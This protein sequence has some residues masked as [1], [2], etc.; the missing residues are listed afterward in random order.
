MNE[1][2]DFI[3]AI[4]KTK[5]STVTGETK[6]CPFC[7]R[8]ELHRSNVILKS[9]DHFLWMENKY[10][11]FENGYQTVLVEHKGC[12]LH[13][14]SYDMSHRRALLSFAYR[15]LQELKA[16]NRFKSVCM[17]KNH[18]LLSGS[19]IAHAHMQIVGWEDIDC[20]HDIKDRDFEGELAFESENVRVNISR[21]P[22]GESFEINIIA[23]NN[24]NGRDEMADA[25]ATSVDYLLTVLNPIHKSYNIAFYEHGDH[26]IA[27]VIPR[28]FS[29]LYV[30]AYAMS[31]RPITLHQV[32]QGLKEHNEKRK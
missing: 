4:A 29:S 18:G 9:E 2:V 28:Y 11:T 5:P 1:Y 32:A 17:I 23:A 27:K 22:R 10:P 20:Y 6:A 14:E 13:L 21:Y 15:C 16:T 24:K 31:L 12:D 7:D 25:I 19:S 26:F 30:T 8:E 3:P